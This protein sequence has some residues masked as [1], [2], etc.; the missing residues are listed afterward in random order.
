MRR[1]FTRSARGLAAVAAVAAAAT[2]LGGCGDDGPTGPAPSDL[3]RAEARWNR[4]GIG[5]A[6]TM[7]QRRA[8]FCIDGAVTYE[9]TVRGGA[10][11]A[12]RDPA[13]GQ[14][15]PAERHQWFRTVR[16]LFDE[17]RIALQRDGVLQEV[18]YD[19]SL[20]YPTRLSLD[21]IRNAADD[22]VLYVTTDVVRLP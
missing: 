19:P 11:V 22:E 9:V 2:L 20:G 18:V 17:T 16:Q 12:M 15:L 13:T 10:I 6:Y 8:C 5:D 14:T 3:A 1:T 4:A 21:P 7:R